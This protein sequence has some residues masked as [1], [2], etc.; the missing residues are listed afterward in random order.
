M[1]FAQPRYLVAGDE[2]IL[3]ELGDEMNMDLNFKALGLKSALAEA[4]IPGVIESVPSFAT[5]LV[6]YDP[7]TI[8][9]ARLCAH[10]DELVKAL[11]SI[12][13]LELF[14]RLIEIPVYYDDPWTRE[15]VE[16][17][18]AKIKPMP[19]NPSF[20]AEQNGLHSVQDLIRYHSTP[21]YWVA[22]IGFWPGLPFTFSMDPTHFLTVPKYNPART[23]TPQG[24]V[25]IGGACTAI[26]PVQTPG[27][28]YMLG[29]TPVPI[30]DAEQRMPEFSRSAVLLVPGDR[31]KYLPIDA[32]EFA[33]IERMVQAGTYRINILT[34]DKFNVGAYRRWCAER[35]AQ[36]KRE[37]TAR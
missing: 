7:L 28:Y 19:H 33:A 6:H 18:S 21:Q 34:Y 32:E 27:G 22:A 25:G 23:W 24:A 29:R 9:R 1:I 8:S 35:E 5:L 3:V 14:S 26:Y 36:A 20:I 12:E 37:V 15:C 2:Y 11:P 16:D 17:Y 31:L 30:W 10:L 13:N 4:K